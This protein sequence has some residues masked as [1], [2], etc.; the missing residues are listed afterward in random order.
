MKLWY[1]IWKYLIS[2]DADAT[3][4]LLLT[5]IIKG[6]AQFPE[7]ATGNKDAIIFLIW[8]YKLLVMNPCVRRYM[9]REGFKETNLQTFSLKPFSPCF[10]HF[11]SPTTV[12]KAHHSR[13]LNDTWF[14]VGVKTFEVSPKEQGTRRKCTAPEKELLESKARKTLRAGPCFM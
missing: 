1:V 6:N 10:S 5:F 7:G 12:R 9:D 14:T 8:I 11:P 13:I 3:V 2:I 4:G